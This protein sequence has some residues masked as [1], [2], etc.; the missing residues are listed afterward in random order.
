MGHTM[1]GQQ[2]AP[3]GQPLALLG[4]S[5]PSNPWCQDYAYAAAEGRVCMLRQE[6]QTLRNDLQS[7]NGRYVEAHDVADTP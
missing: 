2:T 7:C 5:L 6:A 1:H 3:G 4:L